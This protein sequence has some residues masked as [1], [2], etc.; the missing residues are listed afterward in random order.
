M[1]N[2]ITIPVS[3]THPNEQLQ[4]MVMALIH[5]Y[6]L[7]AVLDAMYQGLLLQYDQDRIEHQKQGPILDSINVARTVADQ[8]LEEA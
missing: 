1:E 4:A 3:Q 2:H 6:G 7:T 8:L 5:S